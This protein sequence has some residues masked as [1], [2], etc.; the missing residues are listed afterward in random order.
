MIA[1]VLLIHDYS[2]ATPQGL[3]LAHASGGKVGFEL[4]T[5]GIQLYDVA[6]LMI[7]TRLK[8]PYLELGLKKRYNL[9]LVQ[10]AGKI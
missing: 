1:A 4:A 5:N 9:L 3:L 7:P 6:K 10:Q 8:H 2:Q